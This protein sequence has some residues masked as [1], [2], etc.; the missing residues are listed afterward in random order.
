MSST[1]KK[2][3]AALWLALRS[4]LPLA[5]PGQAQGQK[6]PGLSACGKAFAGAV[7]SRRLVGRCCPSS[8]APAARS[9]WT[10][11]RPHSHA[12][13]VLCGRHQLHPWT[14][15]HGMSVAPALSTESSAHAATAPAT[16]WPP[17]S[18]CFSAV[19]ARLRDERYQASHPPVRGAGLE[20]RCQASVPGRFPEAACATPFPQRP[21]WP[22]PCLTRP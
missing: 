18:E 12:Q 1:L 3:L 14:R 21:T 20:Q 19:A 5:S 2:T 11:G 6:D 10:S 22:A 16:L 4:G 8:G 9:L 7:F 17:P 15:K 13:R